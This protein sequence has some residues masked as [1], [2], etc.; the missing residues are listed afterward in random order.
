[1]TYLD[2]ALKDMRMKLDD[3]TPEEQMKEGKQVERNRGAARAISLLCIPEIW[4]TRFGANTTKR[5]PSIQAS[6]DQILSGL[7]EY[8]E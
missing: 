6:T 1:V 3:G 7:K 5:H 2:L 8:Q 4:P